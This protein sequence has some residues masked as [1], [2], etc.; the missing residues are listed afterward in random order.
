MESYERYRSLV[1]EA[2]EQYRQ[3]DTVKMAHSLE[4]S[5]QY[6]PYLRAETISDWVTQL[7][8]L[9]K[10]ENLI[11]DAD[12]FSNLPEWNQVLVRALLTQSNN[13]LLGNQSLYFNRSAKVKLHNSS[14]I[15]CLPFEM[16]L[17]NE[18]K[19]LKI[20]SILDSFSH[21]CFEP[22]CDLIPITPADWREQLFDQKIDLLLVESA[23]HGN[24]DSWLYRVAQYNKPAGN[25]LTAIIKW[26]KKHDIPTVFW[27][28]ED[29]P[30]FDRFIERAKE[31]DYIFTSDQNCI[32]KYQNYVSSSVYV[33]SLPFAAQP[34]IHNPLIQEPRMNSTFFAG[35]YYANDFEPRKKAMDT[36]LRIATKFGLDIFDRRYNVSGDDKKVFEFPKDL[37]PF[38]RGSL[39][40]EAVVKAYKKYRLGLNVNSVSDSPTMFSRRV[41]ELLACG[42]PVISTE[43]QGI[44][45]FFPGIV[46]TVNSE[47]EILEVLERLMNNSHEWLCQSVQGIRSV[48][49]QHTYR[50]RLAHIANTVGLNSGMSN[51]RDVVVI[52]KP[53]GDPLQFAEMLSKQIF[54]PAQVIIEGIPVDNLLTLEHL[55]AIKATGIKV[56]ALPKDNIV[57]F[58]RNKY[59]HSIVAICDSCHYYGP[60]YL[61]DAKISL[62]FDRQY[63]ISTI[64]PTDDV[65]SYLIDRKFNKVSQIGMQTN[66]AFLGSLAICSDSSNFSQVLN[67]DTNG[68]VDVKIYLH[69][70][71]W[72]EFLPKMTL[73]KISN[74]EIINLNFS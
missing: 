45:N 11:F 30:N 57:S 50:H 62:D 68:Y 43:S 26:A 31:F 55:D 70:R 46:P 64:H 5:L 40:Y 24:N 65:E 38:I 8:Q 35:T 2:W 9:A 14:S 27:N 53:N 73:N 69:S 72:F 23:W 34:K 60:C 58:I 3:G 19:K 13:R 37:Q 54:T 51:E 6:T 10:E 44:N 33:G 41:F 48:F 67:W 32:S 15:S 25:E 12:V 28:K 39:S 74:R 47:S 66:R 71:A 36:L 20:A 29:P 49:T 1:K 7:V 56:I 52:V 4:Q 59:S 61:M 16:T 21:A 17:S 63:D 22:E 42:T 18:P